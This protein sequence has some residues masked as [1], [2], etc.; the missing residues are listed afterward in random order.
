MNDQL[1]EIAF[2][3]DRSGSM[4]ALV[5]P[6]IAGF[7]R[8]L[9]E[10]QQEPGSARFTLVLFDDRYEV[11]VK[12][13]PISEVVELDTTTF[14]PR[15]GTAL[16]DAIGYTIDGLGKRLAPRSHSHPFSPHR[17]ASHRFL[18]GNRS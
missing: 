5:E 3:L 18:P 9:R 14:V 8:L 1:T 10:Q 6:A 13:L 15:G 11:A 4:Q 17:G 7:N 2:I 12:S 16:L